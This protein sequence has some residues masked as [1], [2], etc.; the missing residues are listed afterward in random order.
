MIE[1]VFIVCQSGRFFIIMFESIIPVILSTV[2][3]LSPLSGDILA[4]KTLDLTN[5]QP[6]PRVNEVFSDNIVLTLR[7]LDHKYG[8]Q[9]NNWQEVRK[10][11]KASFTLK[12]GE[13]F[14][15]Q[16][17]VMSEFKDKI[18]KTTNSTFNSQQGFRSSGWLMG[19]GVCH[20]ASFINITARQA[21]LTVVAPVN[22]NFASIPDIPREFGTS[23]FY[24]PGNASGNARQNLYVVN[25]LD[26]EITFSFQVEKDNINLI[27]TRPSKI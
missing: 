4:Q 9:H 14:A 26:H 20:L 23:I 12:P 24:M 15:F 16:E 8:T 17:D 27:I 22:H 10:P 1:Y 18:V 13:V 2:I 5:R 25:N 7:H 11:F 6:D 19:D 21:G 3:F